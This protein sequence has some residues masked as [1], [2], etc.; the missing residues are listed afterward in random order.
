[1]GLCFIYDCAL[2]LLF[3]FANFH[4][5]I[6]HFHQ[7]VHS[8]HQAMIHINL[9]IPLMSFPHLLLGIGWSSHYFTSWISC[10]I[11]FCLTRPDL[12]NN[13]LAH[14]ITGDVSFVKCFGISFLL[15]IIAHKF[16]NTLCFLASFSTSFFL[17][18]SSNPDADSK[19]LR[20]IQSSQG[21]LHF[22]IYA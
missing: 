9:N 19:N 5:F 13:L 2:N 16:L 17:Y 8:T 14:I 7:F 1:M 22:S 18:V 4:V 15:L 11:S 6:N 12:L 10:F 20:T 3:F 21:N